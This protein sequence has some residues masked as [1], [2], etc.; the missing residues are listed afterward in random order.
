[1]LNK[2][3]SKGAVDNK[4]YNNR[5]IAL[6]RSHEEALLASPFERS[7]WPKG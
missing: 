7:V 6:K 2:V 1:M 3:R 5:M 4:T